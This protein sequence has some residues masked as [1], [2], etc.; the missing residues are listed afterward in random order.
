LCECGCSRC[1]S[2]CTTCDLINSVCQSAAIHAGCSNFTAT[3]SATIGLS[4]GQWAWGIQWSNDVPGQIPNPCSPIDCTYIDV[5]S[6]WEFSFT[7]PIV[8]DGRGV[9]QWHLSD[10]FVEFIP[11]GIDCECGGGCYYI[12]QLGSTTATCCDKDIPRGW[13]TC[14]EM[15][16]DDF[17]VGIFVVSQDWESSEASRFFC[18]ATIDTDPKPAFTVRHDGTTGSPTDVILDVGVSG[19]SI[20]FIGGDFDGYICH[21]PIKNE[22]DIPVACINAIGKG[23][24]ATASTSDVLGSNNTGG[25]SGLKC[26][27]LIPAE[28]SILGSTYTV[29]Y[30]DEDGFFKWRPYLK[31]IAIPDMDSHYNAHVATAANTD[32]EASTML[33]ITEPDEINMAFDSD[34]N[35]TICRCDEGQQD[36]SVCPENQEYTLDDSTST[37]FTCHDGEC[38]Q[39][40]T[41]GAYN[42]YNQ[43][44]VIS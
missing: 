31:I 27:E 12:K 21:I 4:G 41:C 34:V 42:I 35:T 2:N 29:T 38:Q 40:A 20:E 36:E 3:F 15:E 44:F 8:F 22:A 14:A 24:S 6:S 1:A 18:S 28:E 37:Y 30:T 39:P 11:D 26:N 32:C 33:I 43:S 23:I 7:L 5:N 9:A 19:L 25:S 17:T 13:P 16:V 10:G